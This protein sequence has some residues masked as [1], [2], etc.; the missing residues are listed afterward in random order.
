MADEILNLN[1]PHYNLATHYS[2]S[3]RL[4]GGVVIYVH[5]TVKYREYDRAVGLTSEMDV[6]MCAVEIVDYNL[7]VV[8]MYRPSTSSS[9]DIF[10]TAFERL[11]E[12]LITYKGEVA[13]LG[14]FSLDLVRDR[15]GLTSTFR[16]ILGSSNLRICITDPTRGDRCI[17]NIFV[18]LHSTMFQTSVVNPALSDHRG[19]LLEIDV[20][21][22][23][24]SHGHDAQYVNRI[25]ADGLRNLL[26]CLDGEA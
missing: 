8:C 2:R 13:I 11:M 6:E 10:F 22:L 14:D 21:L 26:M 16:D 12:T 4:H 9:Y 25:T 19:L 17:D 23:E 20:H 24:G 15:A 7:M 3:G 18:T 5:D 1:I